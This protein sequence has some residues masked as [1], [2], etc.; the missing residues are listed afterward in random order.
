MAVFTHSLPTAPTRP[1][2]NFDSPLSKF[3]GVELTP[4]LRSPRNLKAC[5]L[6]QTTQIGRDKNSHVRHL[7]DNLAHVASIAFQLLVGHSNRVL[8]VGRACLEFVHFA[9]GVVLACRTSGRLDILILIVRMFE[10]ARF[11]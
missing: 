1:D 3:P 8:Q 4:K 10:C 2:F 6:H 11:Q 7:F 9:G 5:R